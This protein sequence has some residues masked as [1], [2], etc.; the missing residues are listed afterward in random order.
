MVTFS[1]IL[2]YG[3]QGFLRNGLLS[4]STISIMILALIVFE[5]LILFNIVGTGSIKSIQDK[6]DI[7]VYFKSNVPEDTILNIK[8]SLEGLT[9]V[10][11]VEYVSREDALVEF[12]KK[13]EGE[14]AIT[15]TLSELEDNPLLSSL[16]IKAKDLENYD[17]IA[18]Y[19]ETPSLGESVEKVSYTQNKIVIDKLKSIVDSMKKSVII[20]TLFLASLAVLVTFNTIRLAIFSA[21]EQIEIMRLV[22]ASNSFIRGPYIVEGIIYGLASA[23]I[24]FLILIPVINITS[25]YIMNFAVE[26][27]IKGYFLSAW[28]Q[29]LLYQVLFGIG[30][31]I[32]SSFIA[33][34][35]YLK[36]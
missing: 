30:L 21:S 13:H 11:F 28:G 1:R 27:D 26:V 23:F 14:V 19:L 9:E 32:V 22:G 16:N 29:L 24:S 34:R 36:I 20:L 6:I 25:P 31:G 12:K 7:S 18:S 3:W 33:I 17:A 15:Q 2:K 10:N 4:A 35:R 8:R 5:G